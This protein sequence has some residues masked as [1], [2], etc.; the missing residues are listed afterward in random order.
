MLIRRKK[1][2]QEG[3]SPIPARQIANHPFSELAEHYKAWGIGRQRGFQTKIDHLRQLT[4]AF[5]NLPLRSFTTRMLEEWQT[6]RMEKNK[7]STVNRMLATLKHM[8]TKAVE[9]EIVE[10]AVWKRVR[11]VKLLLENK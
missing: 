7:P 8:F 2:V 6:Q 3:I 10:E 5:G 1:E 9:W 11:K 4:A